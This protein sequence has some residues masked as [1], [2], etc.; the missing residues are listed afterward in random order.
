MRQVISLIKDDQVHYALVD[1]E[2]GTL[3]PFASIHLPDPD[4]FGLQEAALLGTNLIEAIGLNG[5]RPKQRALPAAGPVVVHEH[6]GDDDM[7]KPPS[8][9]RSPRRVIKFDDV[10]AIINEHPDGLTCRQIAERLWRHLDRQG[11]VEQWM[12]KGVENRINTAAKWPDPPFRTTYRAEGNFKR[13]YMFPNP[14]NN[15]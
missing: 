2:D 5:K 13:R 12:V 10:V 6:T 7:R 11:D 14:T 1:D 4:R 15:N 8:K 9:S 3:V